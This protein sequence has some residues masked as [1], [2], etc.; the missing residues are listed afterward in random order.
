MEKKYILT[1]KTKEFKG[2]TLYRIQA[3]KD[4]SDV[5][6]DTLGGWIE[7]EKIYHKMVIVGSVVRL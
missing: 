7:S 3:V 1:E 4:F 5:K 6:K 2:H